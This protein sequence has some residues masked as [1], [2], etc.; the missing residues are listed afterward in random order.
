MA[1]VTLRK[2][3]R[4]WLAVFA[5]AVIASIVLHHAA[6][7]SG[8]W[9]LLVALVAAQAAF[10]LL[11]RG[12]RALFRL[13][14]R[15]LTLR[16]A[17]SYFLIGVVPIPLLAALLFVVA[18]ILTNQYVA[19]RI[20]REITD[21]GESAARSSASLPEIAVGSDGTVAA[22]AVPWL[23]VGSPAPWAAKLDR[24]AERCRTDR[25]P[26]AEG[27]RRSLAPAARR[28]HRL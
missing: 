24:P 1:P 21:V 23:P 18:Y 6:P 22:S 9:S 8:C 16:L 13:V 12:A 11:W 14:I 25:T 7:E 15:R 5:A 20:R 3:T 2:S 27:C 10:I 4:I 19:N 26:R 17:F 28:S